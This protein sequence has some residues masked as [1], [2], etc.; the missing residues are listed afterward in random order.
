ME[1]YKPKTVNDLEIF[2]GDLLLKV[3]DFASISDHLSKL[4]DR[5]WE[6]V[7]SKNEAVLSEISNYHWRHLGK[8]ASML[9]ACKLTHEDCRQ[10]IANE[11][12]FRRWTEVAHMSFPYHIDF[13]NAVNAMLEG[14][15]D[16]VK[17]LISEDNSLVNNKSPYGHNATMLH[18]A[19]SNGVELW[20]QKVPLNLPEI[21]AYLMEQGA[22]RNAKMKVYGGEYTAAE[23]L[24][25]SAH[26]VNAGIAKE[27]RNQFEP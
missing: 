6:G 16:I 20:R 10:S 24:P 7:Q 15:I 27:L 4:S 19:V 17:K 8:P 11:Y 13:E 9:L 18:Y 12:G 22:N 1:V 26:P 25:S 21:V 3:A 5:M 2:Y 23:L 14:N